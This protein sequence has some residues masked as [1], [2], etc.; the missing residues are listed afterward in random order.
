MIKSLTLTLDDDQVRFTPDGKVALMDMIAA[1]SD[2]DEPETIWDEIVSQNPEILA[3][4]E[5][6]DYKDE[7][8]KVV[9]SDGLA[10]VENMLFDYL[11]D[12][13]QEAV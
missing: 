4:C 2:S 1:L 5:D 12:Q 7:T 8:I 10:M 13:W 9:D 3:Y 11:I 6:F